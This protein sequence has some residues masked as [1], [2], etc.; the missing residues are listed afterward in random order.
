[1][2]T[3][4]QES[5]IQAD[6]WAVLRREDGQDPITLGHMEGTDLVDGDVHERSFGVKATDEAPSVLDKD[7]E[8]NAA[9]GSTDIVSGKCPIC[10]SQTDVL[11]SSET[12]FCEC[13]GSEIMTEAAI[14]FANASKHQGLPMQISVS[15]AM[16]KEQASAV[17]VT[18][19]TEDGASADASS[20]AGSDASTE[21]K[22]RLDKPGVLAC[23]GLFICAG[24]VISGQIA[25]VHYVFFL[26]PYVM[27]MLCS[28]IVLVA[29]IVFAVKLG[30]NKPRNI[31][32]I[33]RATAFGGF[34]T[35][36]SVLAVAPFSDMDA[37]S[38]AFLYAAPL[39]T[40]LEGYLN[41]ARALWASGYVLGT[42]EGIASWILVSLMLT[43]AAY[44]LASIIAYGVC[45]VSGKKHLWDGTNG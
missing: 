28:P 39:T 8:S 12:S 24:V 14:A 18:G 4:N 32:L 41:D 23:I 29:S 1:M 6:G 44:L 31:G 33:R 20:G 37:A 19:S 2:G 25:L 27:L 5:S 36:L 21:G 17:G 34:L 40:G 26:D 3:G 7:E 13:C 16:G 42:W 10:G 11:A 35:F 38:E 15:A 43:L 22:A 9:R 45:S 30:R